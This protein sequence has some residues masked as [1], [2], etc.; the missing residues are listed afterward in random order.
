MPHVIAPMW[1]IGKHPRPEPA[2]EV[3]RPTRQMPKW[4]I[5]V[6]ATPLNQPKNVGYCHALHR[7]VRSSKGKTRMKYAYL[8][9]LLFLCGAAIA[10]QVQFDY[11]RSANFA[12]YKTWQ[13]VDRRP[14]APGDQLLDQDIKRAVDAQLAGKGM[15]RVETGGDLR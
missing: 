8:M 13:G 7:G 3:R 11:D 9:L 5:G 1:L 15:R 12:A 10:Q 2:D 6:E 4:R 14:V